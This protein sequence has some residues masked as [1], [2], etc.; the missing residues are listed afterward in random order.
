MKCP[1]A[2]ESSKSSYWRLNANS[3]NRPYVRR[4]TC[5]LDTPGGGGG[6]GASGGKKAKSRLG[7]SGAALGSSSNA[8]STAKRSAQ[9]GTGGGRVDLKSGMYGGGDDLLAG[10][11]G[12]V[13]ATAMRSHLNSLSSGIASAFSIP[14]GNGGSGDTLLGLKGDPTGVGLNHHHPWA[15]SGFLTDRKMAN[16][17]L[18]TLW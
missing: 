9:M 14:G 1:K 7:S 3:L 11:D 15:N 8:V 5:S 6:N 13:S 18:S 12:H 17:E 16:D 2:S 10:L 4:R